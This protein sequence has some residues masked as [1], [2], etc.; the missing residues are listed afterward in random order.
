[1][2]SQIKD[3]GIVVDK[4]EPDYQVIPKDTSVEQM[5]YA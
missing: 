1:M 5:P 2:T 4:G 3:S